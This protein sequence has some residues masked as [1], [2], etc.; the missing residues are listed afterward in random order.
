MKQ[1]RHIVTAAAAVIVLLTAG[2][3]ALSYAHLADVAGAHGMSGWRQWTWP[4]CLDAFV[5]AG[6]LLM[7]RAALRRQVDPWA[8]VLTVVGSGS[9]IALNVS[10]V[11]ASA[12]AL[13][14]IVAAVPPSASLLAFGA[15]M[16][17]VHEYLAAAQ[18][19]PVAVPQPAPAAVPAQ[20]VADVPAQP[21]QPKPSEVQPAPV[22]PQPMGLVLD[23][24]A[25]RKPHPMAQPAPAA[26]AA[27][28]RPQP[29]RKA[30]PKPAAAA[31]AVDD[32]PLITAARKLPAPDGKA[33][34]LRALQTHL[35]VGQR[36]AQRIQAALASAS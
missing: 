31:A 1:Q 4:G 21:V 29:V 36:R 17:Q 11:G 15:L 28:A 32:A 20:P 26:P 33:P 16:R 8:I 2:A 12:S 10:G 35:G 13:D 18:P 3:F 7:L 30:Q 25:S 27:P 14:H 19:K 24:Q 5:I 34:S 23:F 6:E 9:S 22:Q